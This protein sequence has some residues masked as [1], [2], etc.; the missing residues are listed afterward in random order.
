Q[1]SGADVLFAPYLPDI[2]VVRVATMLLDKPLNILV[3][4]PGN[5][6]S[7]QE[8]NDCGVQRISLGY[9]LTKHIYGQALQA[10]QKIRNDNAFAFVDDMTGT[11]ALDKIL[12]R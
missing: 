3:G 1:E 7:V 4:A 5:N 10:A 9:S 8:L 11:D 12:T 2:D 6:W